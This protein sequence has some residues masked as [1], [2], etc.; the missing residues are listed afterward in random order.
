MGRP[1]GYQ[2]KPLGLDADPV[3]G[4]P[5]QISQEAA[6]LATEAE[7]ISQQVATLRQIAANGTEVGKHADTIRSKAG[8][9]AGQLE[10]LA[11]RYRKVSTI[12]QGWIPDLEKAQAMSVQA[13]D[14]AE[15]PYAKLH[16][17]VALPSGSNLTAQ[18]KQQVQDYHNSMNQA[19]N[20]LNAAM[21]LLNRAT[22]L[23][24]SSGSH[25][26]D[27]INSACNDGM[28][29]HHSL[30]GDL[31]GWMSDAWHWVEG[32][33]D[34]VADHW[35][36]ILKDLCTVLEAIATILAIIAL[37]IPGL[38]IIVILGIAATA[39]A[40]AGRATLAATGHGSWMD[41][42][43]DAFALLTF[44]TGKILG[45]M[46]KGVFSATEDAGK[47]LVQ[48]ERDAS[49]LGKLGNVLHMA[50]DMVD[51]SSVVK[52]SVS[53]LDRIGLRGLS[54]GITSAAGKLSGSLEKLSGI[55][56]EKASPSLA[57]TLKEAGTEIRP[58]ETALYGGEE[59]S[60]MMTRK[61]ALIAQRF[62][63]S[64]QIAE[65]G[66]RFNTYLNI[67][68][69]VFASANVA[70]QWDHW[71]GGIQWYG[72]NEETPVVNLHLPGTEFYR[73]FK[74]SWKTAGG[75]F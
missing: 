65:L 23:R 27:M 50:S 54:E 66:A 48:A 2:W 49:T 28:R 1:A 8:D 16:Q 18:Q 60:L 74:E 12:L 69:G 56:L 20:E 40:L 15:Q 9:L 42:A 14:Q 11:V 53:F 19:Q 4:E 10:I 61:M 58:L 38:D 64:Q 70:D 36:E 32:A 44:G 34:W 46:M 3:P 52:A 73:D 51:N 21:A 26:A 41:V 31:T 13:L 57:T 67:Q 5:A 25:H 22:S 72:N 39:L 55:A 30:W 45:N 43:L 7:I 29:D 17:T 47:V 59:E 6:H 63:E 71:V 37:F 75:I 68:R 33:A 62:P 24:D 35:V